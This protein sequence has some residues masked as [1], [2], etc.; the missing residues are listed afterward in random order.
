MASEYW[1]IRN[2]D[3]YLTT[4]R[5]WSKERLC[6][7]RYLRRVDAL[8]DRT[9]AADSIVH[10]RI[11]P[12]SERLYLCERLKAWEPIVR[13]TIAFDN[14]MALNSREGKELHRTVEALPSHHN[15]TR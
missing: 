5:L 10:V 2:G 12:R 13:A 11:R 6:A 8:Y 4:S 15:P 1:L 3:D 14:V 7:Q 9:S